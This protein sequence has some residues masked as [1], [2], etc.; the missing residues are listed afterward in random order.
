MR[1]NI[2]VSCKAVPA[3]SLAPSLAVFTLLIP[4]LHYYGLE[5][6]MESKRKENEVFLPL[7]PRCGN[8]KLNPKVST[9]QWK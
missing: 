9:T 8:A 2:N 3:K 1:K 5:K 6:R 7:F 4:Y